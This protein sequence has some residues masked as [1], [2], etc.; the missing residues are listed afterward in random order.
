[1]FQILPLLAT[2]AFA[3]PQTYGVPAP[4]G[5]GG[6][7][8]GHG[9]GHAIGGGHGGGHGGGLAVGGHGGG[10]AV[11]GG[12][13]YAGPGPV[14]AGGFGGGIALGPCGGGLVRKADGRCVKPI[15]S[16]NIFLYNAPRPKVSFG[17]P[18]VI[19][20]PKIH[21]NFVFVRSQDTIVGPKPVVVPPPQQK[22]LVYV[23]SKRPEAIGQQLIEVPGQ[24]EEPEVFF[25]NYNEGEN[26]VLPGGIDLQT[27]LSQSAGAGRVIDA[28][29]G[30][31]GPIGGAI[32]GPIGGGL[33]GG[34]GGGIGGGLG[35]AIGGGHLQGFDSSDEIH[36]GFSGGALDAGGLVGGGFGGVGGGISGSYSSNSNTI[37]SPDQIAEG[38]NVVVSTLKRAVENTDSDDDFEQ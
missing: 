23:L 22:T 3:R 35:G 6:F 36:G 37:V 7:R 25:V 34:L 18:P 12:R 9:G 15:V 26:P 29:G 30:L 17:P 38:S 10:L 11:G 14:A 16:R 4:G 13:G 8:G 28:S 1:M 21:Y 20:D 31:G 33:V 27:A 32:G 19:P 24:V 2:L 5:P